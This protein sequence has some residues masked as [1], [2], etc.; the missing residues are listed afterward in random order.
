MMVIPVVTRDKLQGVCI[1]VGNNQAAGLDGIRNKALKLGMKSRF[2][3]F[4]ELFGK[5]MSVG[6]AFLAL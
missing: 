6:G 2:D 5:C 1:R 4:T 3:M